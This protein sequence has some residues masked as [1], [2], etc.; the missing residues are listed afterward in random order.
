MTDPPNDFPSAMGVLY[1]IP[2][3]FPF[4][5]AGFRTESANMQG[6]L[7]MQKCLL[8]DAEAGEDAVEQVVGVDRAGHLAERVDRPAKR[9][10]QQLWRVVV[11]RERMRFVQ[12]FQTRE[13]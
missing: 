7:T 4:P 11:C 9:Q 3:R 6:N 1:R 12:P 8:P 10:R 13:D 5:V 2:F